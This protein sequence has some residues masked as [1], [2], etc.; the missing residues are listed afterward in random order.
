MYRGHTSENCARKTSELAQA[1]CDT[2][3]GHIYL[4]NTIGTQATTDCIR[5]SK[6]AVKME[7]PAA[8]NTDSPNENTQSA[9]D[10]TNT[11]PPDALLELAKHSLDKMQQAMSMLDQNAQHSMNK[12]ETGMNTLAQTGQHSMNTLDQNT[13]HNTTVS[14]ETHKNTVELALAPGNS[15]NVQMDQQC[16]NSKPAQQVQPQAQLLRTQSQQQQPAADE[17][18]IQRCNQDHASGSLGKSHAAKRC[19]SSPQLL[20]SSMVSLPS[21]V[22]K[23]SA[24]FS[25]AIREGRMLV[26]EKHLLT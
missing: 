2:N 7:A 1:E 26:R 25:H 11:A 13:Q 20:Q 17:E 15:E 5:S 14:A 6:D 18:M 19:V 3:T 8:N 23:T 24:L 12:L 16:V 9:T 21:D 10:H 22:C 4:H